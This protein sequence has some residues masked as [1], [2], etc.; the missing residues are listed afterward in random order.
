MVQ[1]TFSDTATG[2]LV[3]VLALKSR[4]PRCHQ[5]PRLSYLHP[6]RPPDSLYQV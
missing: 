4:F 6:L 5:V 2:R 3:T 1:Q